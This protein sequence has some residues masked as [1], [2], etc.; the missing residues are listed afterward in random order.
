MNF[1]RAAELCN[2]TQPTLTTAIRKLEEEL[3][4][5]LI[6][7]ERNRTHLTHLGQ[8]ILPL[9]EQVYESSH[10]AQALARDLNRGDRIPL[11]LGVSDVFDKAH[12]LRA[13]RKVRAA[14]SGLELHLEGGPDGAL[15][16][17]LLSGSLDMAILDGAA[18]QDERIRFNSLYVET[19]RV[20]IPE[21]DPLSDQPG[22]SLEDVLDRPWNGLLESPV[23][24]AFG[25]GTRPADMRWTQRHRATRPT[26]AQLLVLSGLGLALAGSHEP[27][28]T[29]LVLRPLREPALSRSIGIAT[30]RGRQR[31][32]AATTLSRLLRAQTYAGAE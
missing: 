29:G 11:S 5:P 7:R 21:A 32:I 19:M 24:A 26:E 3:G 4:G 25:N 22:L 6:H 12:L 28:L 14:I 2:V 13:M 8:M 23:H 18:A 10:A 16:D 30:V 15:S 27:L 17:R 9:L 20:L 1:T 31:S